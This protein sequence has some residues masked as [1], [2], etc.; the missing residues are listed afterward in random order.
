MDPR[1]KL[2]PEGGTSPGL[3]DAAR[4][5]AQYGCGPVRFAGAEEALYERHLLFD[6]VVAL[7]AAGARER[8]DAVA[9]SLRDVLS[10]RWLLTE[11]TYARENAKRVYYLSMEFLIGRS[12]ANNVTNL[13]LEGLAEEAVRRRNV[14][15]DEVLER[16]EARERDANQD[17]GKQRE[18]EVVGQ[19]RGEARAVVGHEL[20][21]RPLEQLPPAEW[22]VREPEREPSH[23]LGGGGGG[24]GR[25]A[26]IA[27]SQSRLVEKAPSGISP[28]NIRFDSI[29]MPI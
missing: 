10:Q 18:E 2:T 1:E 4:V 17:R 13:Q 25:P 26:A 28:S 20:L 7:D 3:A 29:W 21:G 27:R 15:V 16:E 23:A 19:L 9:R 12:L 8:Y 14:N 6:N 24:G 22:Q 11:E 5:A